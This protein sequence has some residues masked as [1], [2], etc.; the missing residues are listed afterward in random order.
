VIGDQ[1]LVGGH[2]AR[3][4]Y[5]LTA[6]RSTRVD[7]TFAF[8]LI[9]AAYAD[10]NAVQYPVTREPSFPRLWRSTNRRAARWLLTMVEQ[11]LV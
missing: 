1:R 4:L 5:D 7:S 11:S 10:E 3:A 8:F 2:D 6:D 9:T